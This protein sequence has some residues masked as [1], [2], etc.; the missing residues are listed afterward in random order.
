MRRTELDANYF[1]VFDNQVEDTGS[2]N[3]ESRIV[4]QDVL[5][6]PLIQNTVYL[7]PGALNNKL[8]TGITS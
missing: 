7:R 4:E 3:V 8:G 1:R 2:L 5:H 6:I